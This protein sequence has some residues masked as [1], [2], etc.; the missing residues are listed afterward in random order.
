MDNW[1][2]LPNSAHT[3]RSW[4]IHEIAR[5]FRLED[6]W[7][8]P[9]RGGP[10]DFRR[11]VALFAALDPVRSSSRAVRTLFAIRLKIGKLL[12]WDDR[13]RAPDSGVA[14]LRD[15]LPEDL[16]E[17]PTGPYSSTLPYNP[18]YLTADEWAAEVVSR[19]VDG[20]L[21]L[22]WVEDQNG[23]HCGQMA[24]LVKPHGLLGTVY[25]AAI[26]PFRYAIVYPRLMRE[27]DR[28][29]RAH[30]ADPTLTSDSR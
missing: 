10:G 14:T 24:V 27:M 16:R 3:S 2:Q 5:D 12:R 21:H 13:E 28:A 1:R 17:G 30:S 11:L 7:Q 25:M 15:R 23:D 6:V 26:A 19:T 8:L 4:R 18:L 22:G 9:T 20:V 29:W